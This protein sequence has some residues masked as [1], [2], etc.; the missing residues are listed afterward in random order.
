MI[1][2]EKA[3]FINNSNFIIKWRRLMIKTFIFRPLQVLRIYL[4]NSKIYIKTNFNSRSKFQIFR[5]S[6]FSH[7]KKKIC[8]FKFLLHSCW[9]LGTYSPIHCRS[10]LHS[11][12]LFCKF[13]TNSLSIFKLWR[14]EKLVTFKTNLIYI[15][16]K[17]VYCLYLLFFVNQINNR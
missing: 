15:I 1:A 8:Y 2:D 9:I 17:D 12:A 4:I 6:E 16:Q 7:E 14:R 13:L 10:I 11:P 3:S 5:T